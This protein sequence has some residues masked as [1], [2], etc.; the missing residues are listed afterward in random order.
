MI[1]L[2]GGR[3]PLMKQIHQVIDALDLRI[4]LPQEADMN[5]TSKE[6]LHKGE[7]ASWIEG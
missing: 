7:G 1:R 3:D 6:M 4:E 2:E 5:E